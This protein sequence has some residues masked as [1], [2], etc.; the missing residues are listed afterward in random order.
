MA[1][2]RKQ[3]FKAGDLCVLRD[4]ELR[5]YYVRRNGTDLFFQGRDMFHQPAWGKL[6]GAMPF[7]QEA[8]AQKAIAVL[9]SDKEK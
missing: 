1:V 5:I 8:E 2:K 4:G 6:E 9:I 7:V 3:K